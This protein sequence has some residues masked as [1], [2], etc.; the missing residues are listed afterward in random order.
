MHVHQDPKPVNTSLFSQTY[1]LLS[2]HTLKGSSI[3]FARTSV[4]PA[5][6]T[7]NHSH[8]F[9]TCQILSPLF[10]LLVS[11]LN[12][13]LLQYIHLVLI[14]FLFVT[15]FT[16]S[17][18]AADCTTKAL[19]SRVM[20]SINFSTSL[21]SLTSNSSSSLTQL[22]RQN[23]SWPFH[24]PDLQQASLPLLLIRKNYFH[25]SQSSQ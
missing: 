4:I 21:I 18:T 13:L 8:S 3:T 10:N 25:C 19:Y 17:A 2:L 9:R 6:T 5:I 14:H 20:I 16:R 22:L 23:H 12:K 15:F 1:K 7:S 11:D 24:H